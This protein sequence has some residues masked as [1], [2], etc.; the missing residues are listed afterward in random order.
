MTAP[1]VLR[2]RLDAGPGSFGCAACP[3]CYWIDQHA[4]SVCGATR[5]EA[6]ACRVV[7]T[8]PDLPPAPSWCPLRTGPVIVEG[9][10]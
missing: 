5:D 6:G 4:E 9:E 7:N 2:V 3:L 10:A 1:V 8:G